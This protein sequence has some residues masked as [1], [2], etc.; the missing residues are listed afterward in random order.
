MHS[1]DLSHHDKISEGFDKMLEYVESLK[2]NTPDELGR[3]FSA[4]EL[5]AAIKRVKESMDFERQHR[6]IIERFGRYPYRNKVV[7]RASTKEE[8]A[9]VEGGGQSFGSGKV[10]GDI[11][12]DPF[13]PN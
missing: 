10:I 4:E 3:T 6:D 2:P 7:R 9:Y 13:Q 8:M 1:E 5:E 12:A 11:Y